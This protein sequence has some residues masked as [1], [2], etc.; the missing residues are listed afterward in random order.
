[1]NMPRVFDQTVN[2]TYYFN[3]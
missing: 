2:L 3:S 1:M